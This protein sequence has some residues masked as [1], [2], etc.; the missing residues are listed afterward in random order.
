VLI[1][2]NYNKKNI[3]N[4]LERPFQ[5]TIAMNCKIYVL[6]RSEIPDGDH[7]SGHVSKVVPPSSASLAHLFASSCT[8]F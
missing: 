8:V 3:T 5:I 2:A 7:G 4:V 1:N 6:R